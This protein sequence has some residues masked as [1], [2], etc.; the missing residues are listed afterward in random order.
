CNS[1][2]HRGRIRIRAAR[3]REASCGLAHKHSLSIDR[4]KFSYSVARKS[5]GR[6]DSLESTEAATSR[7]MQPQRSAQAE[8]AEGSKRIIVQ[9]PLG[10]PGDSRAL[11]QHLGEGSTVRS[12]GPN[13]YLAEKKTGISAQ[14]IKNIQQSYGAGTKIYSDEP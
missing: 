12:L 3:D 9:T 1:H 5:K 10:S 2:R 6:G 11:S 14:D 8:P 7:S 4:C 13:T